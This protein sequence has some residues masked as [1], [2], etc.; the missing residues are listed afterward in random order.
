MDTVS[1]MIAIGKETVDKKELQLGREFKGYAH[2]CRELGITKYKSQSNSQKAQFKD[3]ERYVKIERPDK[4]K[5]IFAEVYSKELPKEDGRSSG[6][7][8]IFK[9]DTITTM[10]KVMLAKSEGSKVMYIPKH[11][12]HEEL[13]LV[14]SYY[15]DL[16]K[17][18][19]AKLLHEMTQT[20]ALL[21]KYFFSSVDESC[22]S[23]IQT[24]LNK[25][26]KQGFI[27]WS[28]TRIKVIVDNE[29]VG[30]QNVRHIAC[31]DEEVSAILK[32]EKA[33]CKELGYA[34][35]YEVSLASQTVKDKFYNKVQ[36]ILNLVYSIQYTY[37][38]KSYKIIYAKRAI[39]EDL[40]SRG[41]SGVEEYITRANDIFI[42]A[43]IK[44]FERSVGRVNDKNLDYQ[45]YRKRVLGIPKPQEQTKYALNKDDLVILKDNFMQGME[46]LVSTCIRTV[47][48]DKLE[49]ELVHRGEFEIEIEMSSQVHED[50]IE[51]DIVKM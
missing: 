11:V 30:S 20:N 36:F 45:D 4:K 33:I 8:A 49:K 26:S 32:V 25:L 31:S 40:E 39:K 13:A 18:K 24:G 27:K 10:L 9:D 22:E 1:A 43:L 3:L 51:E 15:Y 5:I 23:V 42:N 29:K 37:S 35:T 6:N 46:S 38:Y 48:I 50:L 7:N 34:N 41:I 44:K 14:N 12:L 16:R 21:S 19:N 28:E 2:M 47:V 17:S